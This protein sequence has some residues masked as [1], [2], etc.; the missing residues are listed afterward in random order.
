MLLDGKVAIVTGAAR[1]QGEAEA[2]LFARHGCRV[3]LTDVLTAE[4]RAVAADIGSTAV[5]EEHDVSNEHDW[6]Q[7]VAFA[8]ERFGGLD[9]LV[10]NA[11]VHESALL[12]NTEL[13][14][15]ERMIRIN[16]VSCFLGMRAVVGELRA[17]GGGS[18][19]NISSVNGLVGVASTLAYSATKWAVRG[20]TKAAAIELGPA[21]IRVNSV[22]P[23]AIDTPMVRA[24]FESD[25]DSL[26][27]RLPIA[28]MAQPEE[29]AEL[30]LFLASDAS[31][32]CTGA[33]FVADGGMSA[34]PF[35]T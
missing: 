24:P 25:I 21:G 1:G 33:E 12:E 34:G 22:H 9:I 15:F 5:F 26:V 19:V 11:A 4:G 35:G 23:G 18:I 30:V 20:M 16:Q 2:R 14:S 17:R 8:R 32:Y 31:S 3:V 28:R 29:I 10:N 13:S 6:Q 7:V 27:A